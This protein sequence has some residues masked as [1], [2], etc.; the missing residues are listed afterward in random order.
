MAEYRSLKNFIGIIQGILVYDF[1]ENVFEVRNKN[2]ASYYCLM[3]FVLIMSHVGYSNVT[4][5]Y[6]QLIVS[7]TIPI[8]A[9]FQLE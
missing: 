5:L 7:N 3:P 1:V 6:K 4:V 2:K 9:T 8:S